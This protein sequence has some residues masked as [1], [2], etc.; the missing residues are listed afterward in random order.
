MN[1]DSE[2]VVVESTFTLPAG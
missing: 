2:H 1:N